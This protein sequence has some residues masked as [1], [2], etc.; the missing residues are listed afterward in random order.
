V[1][2]LFAAVQLA[3]GNTTETCA[4]TAAF[5]SGGFQDTGFKAGIGGG[6]SYDSNTGDQTTTTGGPS[7]IVLYFTV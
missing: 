7:A 5:G 1:S 3:G 6:G 2:G 4:T